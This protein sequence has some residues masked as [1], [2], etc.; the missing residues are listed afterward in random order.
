M[1]VIAIVRRFARP[2]SVIALVLLHTAV[3]IVEPS[4][5]GA[6][7]REAAAREDIQRDSVARVR[8]IE[9]AQ[10]IRDTLT[11][12]VNRHAISA[13]DVVSFPFEVAVFPLEL[14]VRGT[15][16]VV[17][18]VAQ[19]ERY[20]PFTRSYRFLTSNGIRPM[21]ATTS[22]SRG[23]LALAVEWTAVPV[24]SVVTQ[25]SQRGY[26]R[27]ALGWTA[28]DASDW[29]LASQASFDR[30]TQERFWGIGIDT[31]ESAG[32]DFLQNIWSAGATLT[33]R[34][35]RLAS[36]S[37]G[38]H[39]E[40]RTI[41]RGRD[42]S[43]PDVVDQY[44]DTELPGLDDPV[45]FVVGEVSAEVQRV[46]LRD[47]QPFGIESSASWRFFQGVGPTDEDF[48]RGDVSVSVHLP[49]SSHHRL[50]LSG[51]THAIADGDGRVPFTHT[52]ALGGELT[53]RS[54]REARFRA[55]AVVAGS[56][57]WHWELWRSLREDVRMG[58]VLF[59]DGGTAG[60][61]LS[62]LES[63][64]S[65]WGFGLTAR[66]LPGLETMGFIA[67]GDDGTRW[68]GS[69]SAGAF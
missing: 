48:A 46:K 64:E 16:A 19:P 58:A 12:P 63:G 38:A 13:G 25:V 31:P 4:P 15:S 37:V 1:S 47:G 20:A 52:P 67:F 50:T 54:F 32:A 6:Q 35:G 27:Y 26:Q 18:F 57:E 39:W 65:S 40:R 24:I 23:G 41:G 53:L 51:L 59:L 34:A 17:G 42:S 36:V 68:S 5:L 56:V 29:S 3:A 60:P 49:V 21:V 11:R 8:A 44:E 69:F 2:V 61:D 62:S 66:V 22:G 55:P 43:L 28:V 9:R 14:V 10:A 33:R 7:E 30:Q 45:S